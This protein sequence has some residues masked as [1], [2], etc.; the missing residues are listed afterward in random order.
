M[1]TLTKWLIEYIRLDRLGQNFVI[2]WDEENV[3]GGD[4]QKGESKIKGRIRLLSLFLSPVLPH[5]SFQLV[6]DCYLGIT[7]PKNLELYYLVSNISIYDISK[8]LFPVTEPCI[9]FTTSLL[10]RKMG[11][12]TLS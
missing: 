10:I 3:L 7:Y 9:R 4:T 5:S 1:Q 12:Q 11:K 2:E 8:L 6:G